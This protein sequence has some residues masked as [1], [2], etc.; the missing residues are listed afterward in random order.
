VFKSLPSIRLI[1][2]W[3]R[4]DDGLPGS[5]SVAMHGARYGPKSPLPVKCIFSSLVMT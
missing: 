3:L 2:G 5:L 1:C 4:L